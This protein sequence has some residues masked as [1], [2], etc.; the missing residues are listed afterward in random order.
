MPV[1]L[2][3]V[4]LC[5]VPAFCPHEARKAGA[6]NQEGL[7]NIVGV[8]TGY[9][10]STYESFPMSGAAYTLYDQGQVAGAGGTAENTRTGCI[11]AS[12]SSSIYGGSDEVMPK[13]INILVA[14]YLGRS[15]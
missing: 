5:Q 9:W 15:S 10:R 6:S 3:I 1:A 11:D 4:S 14:L 8:G 2:R 12:R 7:P 13:S